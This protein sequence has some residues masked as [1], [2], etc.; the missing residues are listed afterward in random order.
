M[1]E[2]NDGERLRT[3]AH[4]GKLYSGTHHG[5][6]KDQHGIG[7]RERA[8]LPTEALDDQE[9]ITTRPPVQRGEE[10]R[11]HEIAP[12]SETVCTPREKPRTMRAKPARQP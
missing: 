5:E 12:G 2:C 11:R 10:Y 3:A 1:S 8:E 9:I 7:K 6:H 4:A